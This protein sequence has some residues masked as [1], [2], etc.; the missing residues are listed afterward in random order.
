LRTFCRF[1]FCSFFHPEVITRIGN[2]FKILNKF[3]IAIIFWKL[4]VLL[5]KNLNLRNDCKK[6][7]DI[8]KFATFVRSFGL[9]F[10]SRL[11][12]RG[13][14]LFFILERHFGILKILYC[15]CRTWRHIFP[16]PFLHRFVVD[17]RQ[18]VCI[19]H[20]RLSTRLGSIE[21]AWHLGYKRLLSL[22]YHLIL[23]QLGP[24]HIGIDFKAILRKDSV[25]R[26][27]SN[28]LAALSKKEWF[29]IFSI[30][31]IE[32]E[33][34]LIFFEE[35][36]SW[37]PQLGKKVRRRRRTCKFSSAGGKEQ[38]RASSCLGRRR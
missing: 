27:R 21:H 9:I 12:T 28:V 6:I 18:G 20:N 19:F 35:S 37:D 34:E 15:H 13:G 36:R 10:S 26:S 24:L 32:K 23:R 11:L 25:W 16:S 14:K 2:S 33:R 31:L 38:R 30:D 4:Y 3:R 5:S 7:A 1:C 8:S 22:I 17:D 29:S